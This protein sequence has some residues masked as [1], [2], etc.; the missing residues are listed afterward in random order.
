MRLCVYIQGGGA[1]YV[2]GL[3]KGRYVPPKNFLVF[4]KAYYNTFYTP[5]K[6]DMMST[7]TFTIRRQVVLCSER[8]CHVKRTC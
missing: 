1:V 3:R 2:L 8:I 6:S 7:S 4:G 5:R